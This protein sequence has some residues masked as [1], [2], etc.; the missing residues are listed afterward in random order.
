MEIL[1]NETLHAYPKLY[2][3]NSLKL[4]LK[5]FIMDEVKSSGYFSLSGDSTP[6]HSH[7]DQ[8]SVVLLY[9]DFLRATWSHR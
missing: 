9:V 6:D 2:V 1:V 8:L 3:K 4:Q 7:I 5:K